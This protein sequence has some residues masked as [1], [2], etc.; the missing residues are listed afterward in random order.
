MFDPMLNH[1]TLQ[2]LMPIVSPRYAA[3][4]VLDAIRWNRREVILPYRLKYIGFI[5]DLLLPQ[6]LSEWLL[7]HVS[8]RRP[9]DQFQRENEENL[10]ERKRKLHSGGQKENIDL[11]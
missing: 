5:N 3:I 8:G 1:V 7:F 4:Q 2:L 9:L 6:W 11:M 10:R